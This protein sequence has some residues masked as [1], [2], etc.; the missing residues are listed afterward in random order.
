VG[1]RYDYYENN[2]IKFSKH[3]SSHNHLL[4]LDMIYKNVMADV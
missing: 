4:H 2:C 3:F 1:E